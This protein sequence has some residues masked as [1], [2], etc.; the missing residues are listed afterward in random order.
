MLAESEV[1]LASPAGWTVVAAA[2]TDGS[3][4]CKSEF[5]RLLG[6][7]DPRQTQVAVR[8]LS[9]TDYW[10][11]EAGAAGPDRVGAAL[12]EQ[13]AGR[14]P[15]LVE[16]DPAAEAEVRALVQEIRAALPIGVVS[17]VYG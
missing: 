3:A 14:Q 17:G 10:L 15:D 7:G 1:W 5:A 16:E 2:A 6:R 8:Q 9:K 13:R 12:A 4:G 11:G